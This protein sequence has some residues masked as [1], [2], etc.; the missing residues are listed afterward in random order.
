M[1]S[2]LG[3]SAA[4]G[5]VA[6]G[7][8]AIALGLIKVIEH[9]IKKRANGKLP[10]GDKTMEIA[11]SKVLARNKVLEILSEILDESKT[12]NRTLTEMIEVWKQK[13]WTEEPHT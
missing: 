8:I 7:V 1:M 3:V 12:T 6:G 4:E 13:K 2:I 9:L 11:V 5:A 10:A